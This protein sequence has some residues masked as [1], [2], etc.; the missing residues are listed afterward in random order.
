MKKKGL[1]KIP[2]FCAKM[3]FFSRYCINIIS[4]LQ[5]ITHF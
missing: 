1:K 5:V 4:R 3:A 2:T